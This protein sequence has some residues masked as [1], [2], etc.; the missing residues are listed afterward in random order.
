MVVAALVTGNVTVLKPSEQTSL[1]AAEFAKIL[2]DSGVPGKA[3]AFLPGRGEIIGRELVNSSKTDMICFTGSKAVGLEIISKAAIVHPGQKSIKRFI[4]ELGGKNAIIVDED[5]DLDEAVKGVIYSA[6]GFAGQKCSACSRVIAVGDSYETFITRLCEA[7]SDLICGDAKN[8]ATLVGPVIDKETHK[9]IN[10]TIAKAEKNNRLAF[11][12]KETPNGY[13]VTPTIFRDVETTSDLWCEE[14]FG[15]VLACRKAATFEEALEVANQ[16][17]YALTGGL[18][19][20][21]PKNIAVAREEFRV[22]NLYINRGCT[23]ALVC[24]QPFGGFRMSGVGSK[25]GGPD[26]LI[27][28]MEPRTIS[29]NTM[30]RGFAPNMG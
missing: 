6:F 23:G 28:F 15:P 8:P 5:A 27:Q 22:G 11:R 24:R 9:R 12:G 18:F 7:A 26:Y 25:A 21:S 2:L 13:F 16:S 14:I 29:E 1:V 3:F 30:R 4:A 20:R 10:E 19:S 17:Q